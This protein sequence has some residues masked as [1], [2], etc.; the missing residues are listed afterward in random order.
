ME[1][2]IV[3]QAAIDVAVLVQKVTSHYFAHVAAMHVARDQRAQAFS[4]SVEP[5]QIV[6]VLKIPRRDGNQMIMHFKHFLALNKEPETVEAFDRVWLTGALLT[7]GDALRGNGYFNHEPEVEIIRHLR[8]GIAHGNKF[9]FHSRVVDQR[10]G[11]LKHPANI[12]RYSDLQ[13][14]PRHQIDTQL[15]GAEVL[16]AWGGP[17]A[18]MDCLTVLGIHL[19]N[20]GHGLPAPTH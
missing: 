20:I 5:G 4:P 9:E 6:P 7:V 8:N 11:V 2:K 3:N 12:F 10:S 14:M 16:W 19:W 1:P 17:D 13:K 15:A 18:I